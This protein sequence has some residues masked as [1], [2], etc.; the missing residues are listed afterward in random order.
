MSRVIGG[1]AY[2]PYSR[3]MGWQGWLGRGRVAMW[4]RCVWAGLC[5]EQLTRGHGRSETRWLSGDRVFQAERM[6]VFS[7]E[8]AGAFEEHLQARLAGAGGAG[9]QEE[10]GRGPGGIAAIV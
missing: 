10:E 8:R 6:C 1:V 2:I 3:R 9:R 4:W 5:L 7:G